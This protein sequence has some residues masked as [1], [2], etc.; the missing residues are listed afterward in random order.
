MW[1]ATCLFFEV[2]VL[3]AEL[4][5]VEVVVGARVRAPAG[6][7]DDVLEGLAHGDVLA[8]DLVVLRAEEAVVGAL[9]LRLQSQPKEATPN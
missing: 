9:V 4:V 2:R 8:A 3:H 7:A 6:W 1:W 5:L